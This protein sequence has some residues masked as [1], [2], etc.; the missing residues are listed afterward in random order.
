MNFLPQ[1]RG[2]VDLQA[3][4]HFSSGFWHQTKISGVDVV[5]PSA[6]AQ[7]PL[8]GGG[9]GYYIVS[10]GGFIMYLKEINI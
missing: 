5:T 3:V 7:L 9:V 4:I 8:P 10:S 2:A 6:M 1:P